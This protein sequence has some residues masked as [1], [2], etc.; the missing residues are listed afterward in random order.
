MTLPLVPIGILCLHK[1]LQLGPLQG[2]ILGLSQVL[3][4]FILNIIIIFGLGAISD[5]MIQYQLWIERYADC[6]WS[7]NLIVQKL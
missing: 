5:Y 2:F 3:A 4:L 6:I 1:V 7:E